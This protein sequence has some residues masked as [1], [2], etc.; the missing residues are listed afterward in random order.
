MVMLFL[1]RNPKFLRKLSRKIENSAGYLYAR[2]DRKIMQFK[3]G[4]GCYHPDLGYTLK[5]GKFVFTER[6]F[7]NAYFINSLGVRD[8]E[9][10]LVRPEI[11]ILGDSFALG[12]GVNQEETFAKLLEENTK[13]KTLNTSVPS[14]GTVREMLMLRRVDVSNLKCLIIQYCADDYDE[15]MRFY[16]NGNCPQIMREQTFQDMMTLQ[17]RPNKYFFGKYLLLKIKKKIEEHKSLIEKKAE[18]IQ[19]NEV[20]LFLHVLGQNEDI[21][22]SVP[23]IVFEMSGKNQTSFFIKGLKEK[24]RN[25]NNPSFIKD[26]IILDMLQYMREEYFYVLDDHLNYHGHIFVADLLTDAIKKAGIINWKYI[27]NNRDDILMQQKRYLDCLINLKLFRFHHLSVNDIDNETV[28]NICSRAMLEQEFCLFANT[29]QDGDEYCQLLHRRV[30]TALQKREALPIVRFADG[31]YAF[32]NYTLACNGLYEQ[33]E[34]I[35]AIKNV[36]PEH[37]SSMKY[38]ADNGLLAPL[39]F[40]GN[41]NVVDRTILSFLHRK[42]DSSGAEF[43]DFLH[44]SGINLSPENYI[45]FYVVYAYLSSAQFALTMNSKNICI[46]NSQYDKEKCQQWFD[47]FSSH[48]NLSFVDIPPQYVAT[49]WE[50][51]KIEILNKI[52]PQTDLCI[53]G[54]GVGALLIC[55]D[56]ARTFSIPAIDAG[57]VFNMMNGRVDNQKDARLFT[58]RKSRV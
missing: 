34:S 35:K 50:E 49:R 45:P 52:P 28:A 20:D 8:T 11:V 42:K 32:Y 43:L 21:L 10:A 33:A 14:Y 9:E 38:L 23:I 56:V 6:E 36:M 51:I 29:V 27:C 19:L 55:T 58:L 15:N 44:A 54:A 40:L 53:V 37:I 26:I 2:G 41:S 47:Q 48:P 30:L 13:L 7:S 12:W 4:C 3:E 1:L 16:M 17:G 46:L 57:H 25:S 39:I 18:D 31:E 22:S 24:M 5:P